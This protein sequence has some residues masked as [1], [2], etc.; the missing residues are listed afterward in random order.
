MALTV[1]AKAPDFTLPSTAG[2]NFSLHKDFKNKVGIVYFYPKDFSA[3]CTVEACA[4][5]DAFE[6]FRGIDVPVV[7]ISADDLETHKRFRE[8]HKLPFHLLTDADKS[9]S[10]SFDVLAPIIGFIQRVTFLIDDT[11]TI[12]AVYQD[13][14]DAR[15]HIDEMIKHLRTKSTTTSI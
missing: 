13:L 15:S 3:G 14:F 2:G 7:G 5:R 8:A 4:F 6:M 1:G 10:K 9:V 12:A 11:M